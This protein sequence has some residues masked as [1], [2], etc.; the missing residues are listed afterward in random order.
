MAGN[1]QEERGRMNQ[2][3]FEA[4]KAVMA[5]MTPM[6][7]YDMSHPDAKGIVKNLTESAVAIADALLAELART[8]PAEACQWTRDDDGIYSTGCGGMWEFTD[9]TYQYNSVKFC[10]YCG[11]AIAEPTVKE[12]FTPDADGWVVRIPTDPIPRGYSEVRFTD[13]IEMA[14]IWSDA[15]WTHKK[16]PGD[17]DLH[18]THYRPA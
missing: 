3:R 14:G 7:G 5:A 8:E 1:R 10:P 17:R 2:Q 16:E 11:K 4:A 12:S 9:G 15:A 6:E 18:I 13:G